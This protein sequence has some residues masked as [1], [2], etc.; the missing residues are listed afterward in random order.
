MKSEQEIRDR[1]A[2]EEEDY[3]TTKELYEKAAMDYKAA[4]EKFGGMA[5]DQK[6]SHYATLL[7][8]HKKQINLLRWILN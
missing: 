8:E 5:N 2:M 7:F 1:L 3:K 4:A 6:M